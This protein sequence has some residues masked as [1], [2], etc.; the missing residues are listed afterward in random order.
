M[1]ST[2]KASLP[3]AKEPLTA[4]PS[5]PAPRTPSPSRSI[6]ELSLQGRRGGYPKGLGSSNQ[7]I[8]ASST[9]SSQ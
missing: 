3:R 4:L 9:Y 6:H 1:W 8:V 5:V 7:K 2:Y